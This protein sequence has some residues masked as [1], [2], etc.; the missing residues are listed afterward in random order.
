MTSKFGKIKNLYSKNYSLL[1][2]SKK[3]DISQFYIKKFLNKENIKIRTKEEAIKYSIVKNSGR[4]KKGQRLSKK[5]EFKS[6]RIPHNKGKKTGELTEETK[7]KIKKAINKHH[8]D[9]NRENNKLSN[10]LFIDLASHRRLHARAYD[11]LVKLGLIEDYI[12]WFKN[13]YNPN[14]YTLE[15][16]LSKLSKY[17]KIN[18]TKLMRENNYK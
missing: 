12:S 17:K 15:E 14:L 3:F 9:L 6:N 8:V 5:T 18:E 11:Y 1:Y 7:N 2:L 10:C 4:I 13:K 16:Y